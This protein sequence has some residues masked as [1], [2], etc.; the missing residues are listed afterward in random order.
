[1]T[2][3]AGSEE[4]IGASLEALSYQS[5]KYLIAPGFGKCSLDIGSRWKVM[6]ERAILGTAAYWEKQLHKAIKTLRRWNKRQ[7]RMKPL[8]FGGSGNSETRK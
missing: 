4:G 7:G 6:N 1:V 5:S 3:S 2:Y 8:V